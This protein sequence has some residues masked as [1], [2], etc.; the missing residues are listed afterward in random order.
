MLRFLPSNESAGKEISTGNRARCERKVNKCAPA[1]PSLAPSLPAPPES[2]RGGTT[3]DVHA[4][5]G[6]VTTWGWGTEGGS[7]Q[8]RGSRGL[9]VTWALCSLD[10]GEGRPGPHSQATVSRLAQG[11]LGRSS[12][13]GVR[14]AHAVV[15]TRVPRRL[16]QERCQGGRAGVQL[17]PPWACTGKGGRQGHAGHW[18]RGAVG[19]LPWLPLPS[20]RHPGHLRLG[21]RPGCGRACGCSA[22]EA[23]GLSQGPTSPRRR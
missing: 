1:V 3:L 19:V 10:L 7:S 14:A 2:S 17:A 11:R 18:K 16:G 9:R 21:P 5:E 23:G 4:M 8:K 12:L 6:K 20:R 22:G 13:Q 15:G